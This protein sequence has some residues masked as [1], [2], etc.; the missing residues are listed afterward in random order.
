V[1]VSICLLA[2]LPAW[3]VVLLFAYLF[4]CVFVCMSVCPSVCPFVRLSVCPSVSNLLL[5]VEL[6]GVG[7]VVKCWPSEDE[8]VQVSMIL[9][10]EFWIAA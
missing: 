4:V 5:C 10:T 9:M 6:S 8:C 3:L 1:R 7:K 2:C